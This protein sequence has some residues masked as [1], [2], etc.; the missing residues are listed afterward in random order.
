M[1]WPAPAARAPPA[2]PLPARH[3]AASRRARQPCR[4]LQRRRRRARAPPT[5]MAARPGP[6]APSAPGRGR[7]AALLLALRPKSR[8]LLWAAPHAP[9][10]PGGR[11]RARRSAPV[12]T[13]SQPT[14]PAPFWRVS[15]LAFRCWLTCL[16]R[17]YLLH[18]NFTSCRAG[19]RARR[20]YPLR[21][22]R[23]GPVRKIANER[24]R[25]QQPAA[26]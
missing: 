20:N 3:A 10:A 11:A 1:R 4:L 5:L 8:W 18:M 23:A 13:G 25:T 24:N 21:M 7:G 15:W 2:S 6:T 22:L 14:N 16:D 17:P 12:W 26:K 9:R 19:S